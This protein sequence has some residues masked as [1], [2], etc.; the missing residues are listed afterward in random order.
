VKRQ[1]TKSAPCGV[2]FNENILGVIED[3][4]IELIANEH[5]DAF[6]LRLRDR[7]ALELRNELSV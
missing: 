1:S 2:E 4:L 6:I 3:N 7:L 5:K